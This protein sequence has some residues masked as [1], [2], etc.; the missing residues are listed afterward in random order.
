M[1]T[2]PQHA[3]DPP[4]HLIAYQ[5][6]IWGCRNIAPRL[7]CFA[8][9]KEQILKIAQDLTGNHALF[10]QDQEALGENP[11]FYFSG[12]AWDIRLTTREFQAIAREHYS[13]VA[14]HSCKSDLGQGL[15]IFAYRPGKVVEIG[16]FEEAF[17]KFLA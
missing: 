3:P 10:L 9:K 1:S 6:W 13:E 15:T 12:K 14:D 2:P 7:I 11:S 8:P 17:I 16:V 4:K 5:A